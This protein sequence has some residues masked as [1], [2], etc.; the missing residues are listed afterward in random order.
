MIAGF[1]VAGKVLKEQKFT[2]AAKKA[3]EFVLKTMRNKDGRLYRTYLSDKGK[4]GTAKLNGYLDD[5]AFFIHGLLALHD[6]TGE[7][8]WLGEAKA[9]TD[10]MVQW[11]WDK[12][13]G[14]FFY[15][16][17]DHE[18]LFARS[19]DQFDGAQPS[20]NSVAARDLVRLYAQTKDEKYLDLAQKQFKT[21]AATLKGSP[22]TLATMIAA[23]D[24][25][26]PI[27]P[28][29]AASA[30]K[31]PAAGAAVKSDSVVKVTATADKPAADGTQVVT[32]TLVIDKPWHTYANPVE[33]EMLDETKT[34]VKM[35]GKGDPKV[36][37]IDYPKGTK[38]EDKIVGDYM[39]YE[40]TVT[41]KATVKRAAGNKDPLEVSVKF[42]ACEEGKNGKAG[43]C[44]LPATVTVKMP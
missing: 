16:S 7:A 2:A 37:K 31:P 43:R 20:G 38:V 23:V 22:T 3:A 27:Q 10:L 26:L 4:P 44:L 15:T 6:A 5:Y 42:T 30:K 19:K 21:F 24:E 33:N 36:E 17:H 13:A 40:G 39:I 18:K 9:L 8:R 32:I 11:H 34:V 29:A 35:S 12:D 1:A 28:A 41:I 25:Y 14:G